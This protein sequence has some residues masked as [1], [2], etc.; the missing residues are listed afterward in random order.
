MS[1]IDPEIVRLLERIPAE[2]LKDLAAMHGAGNLGRQIKAHAKDSIARNWL[3][4]L[5]LFFAF[6]WPFWIWVY[7]CVIRPS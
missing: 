4:G 7:W 2:D 6:T 1:G 3:I 5:I